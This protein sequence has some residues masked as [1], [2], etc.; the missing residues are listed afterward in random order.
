MNLR[1]REFENDFLMTAG[2]RTKY[3]VFFC[4]EELSAQT[5]VSVIIALQS[6]QDAGL[7]VGDKKFRRSPLHHGPLY[8]IRLR[9]CLRLREVKTAGRRCLASLLQFRVLVVAQSKQQVA[10]RLASLWR[11]IFLN[12][13]LDQ[14]LS[15][16]F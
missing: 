8:V 15:F 4:V 11:H 2:T 7:A 1:P 10:A 9:G 6:P 3:D 16:R 13:S 12:R 14:G 5:R